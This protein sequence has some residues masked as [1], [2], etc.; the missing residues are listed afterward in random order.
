MTTADPTTPRFARATA[1][2][3]LLTLTLVSCESSTVI[4]APEVSDFF[5]RVSVDGVDAQHMDG[6]PPPAGTGPSVTGPATLQGIT[7]GSSQLELVGSAGFQTVVILVD[8]VEGYYQATL[9]GSVTSATAL[10]TVASRPPTLNLDGAY[11]VAGADGIFGPYNG[12]AI[13]VIRVAGG[14]IQVSVTWD[15][16]ADVDL[17]VVDPSGEEIYYGHRT[18]ASGGELDIDAN[19]ACSTSEFFQENVGW[20]PST[21]LSGQYIVRVDYWSACGATETNYFVTVA[22]RPGSPGG[23]V[24]TFSGTFTGTGTGG[25][26]GDGTQITSFTFP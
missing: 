3:A 13:N 18:S 12:T 10:V 16:E 8:G 1:L 2:A 14:D 7:G 22:L 15:T 4:I 19:A 20:A 26:A 17:H 9:P 23:S 25:G 24:Q 6:Q 5:A 21:A 11:A